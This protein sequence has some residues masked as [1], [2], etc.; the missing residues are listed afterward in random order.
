MQKYKTI[1]KV[2]TRIR[3]GESENIQKDSKN[4]LFLKKSITFV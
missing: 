4:V 3:P 1:S 2:V